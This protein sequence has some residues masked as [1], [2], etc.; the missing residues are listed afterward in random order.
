M[1]RFQREATLPASLNHL[2]VAAVYGLEESDGTHFPVMELVE[3]VTIKDYIAG[4]AG[5][6]GITKNS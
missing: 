2:N 5:V 3:G 4:N 6:P 1:A